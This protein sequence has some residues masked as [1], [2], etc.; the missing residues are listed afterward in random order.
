MKSGQ[1]ERSDQVVT[2][3]AIL[4]ESP[5]KT[6]RI[7]TGPPR[8]QRALHLGFGGVGMAMAAA[9]L[10]LV[11]AGQAGLAALLLITGMAQVVFALTWL[12]EK[13]SAP[14]FSVGSAPGAD[15]YLD[16]PGLQPIH[17]LVRQTPE[18][19]MLELPGAQPCKIPPH[20]HQVVQVGNLRFFIQSTAASAVKGGLGSLVDWEANI[21]H[22]A[23]FMAHGML[24]FLVFA[25]P[26]DHRTDFDLNAKF[27]GVR[28]TTLLPEEKDDKVP[29]WLQRQVQQETAAEVK[30][31]QP[32]APRQ[33]S[34]P[35]GGGD[36]SD[37]RPR[38]NKSVDAKHLAVAS[39]KNAGV[40]PLLNGAGG[41]FMNNIF[42]ADSALDDGAMEALD[43]LQ[44]NSYGEDMSI[45]G[46]SVSD[47]SH[48][49]GPGSGIASGPLGTIGKRNGGGGPDGPGYGGGFRLPTRK[50]RKHTGLRAE[51]PKE[52]KGAL[53]K[54]IIRRVIRRHLNEVRYCYQREL[55]TNS[56]LYGRLIVK[57]TIAPNGQVVTSGVKQS[58]LGNPTV[59]TCI[60]KAVRR[61]LFP[62][63][64]DGGIVMVSYP[65][66]LKSAGGR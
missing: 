60:A 54:S 7:T 64:R 39:I 33:V 31:V 23:S 50:P 15:L 51:H 25:L 65:F 17:P 14:D 1:N 48:G 22:G 63:P 52:V 32:T 41:A 11:L 28:H 38:G 45:G 27:Q 57:F 49:F 18:G 16:H 47:G 26:P 59:E 34:A 21:Y 37:N 46:L 55:Q 42:S 66:V 4:G 20:S 13:R 53:S 58:T 29:F 56:D 9:G 44:G 36:G 19:P 40:I 5:I 2:V 30:E 61:W 3:T 62:K 10:V 35:R 12:K 6:K 43:G 8:L 24:L